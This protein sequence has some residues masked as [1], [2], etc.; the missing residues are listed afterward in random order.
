MKNQEKISDVFRSLSRENILVIIFATVL[1]FI[2]AGAIDLYLP[3]MPSMGLALHATKVDVQHTV[4]FFLIGCA[5][6][7]LIYG[8]LADRFGRKKIVIVGLLIAILGFLLAAF[9]TTI[10]SLLQARLIQGIGVGVSLMMFRTMIC[11]V[12]TG[13]HLV[14]VLSY[15]T[16]LFSMSPIISPVIGGYIEHYLSWRYC[17]L[18]LLL[19][20]VV[21]II[22]F[23]RFCPET[24]TKK[25]DIKLSSLLAHYKT[26]FTHKVFIYNTI[27]GGIGFGIIM[28]YATA[29]AFVFQTHFHLS[30]IAFGWLGIFIGLVSIISKQFNARFALRFSIPSLLVLGNS[31]ILFGGL[32]LFF[33]RNNQNFIS[34]L[35]PILIVV[36]GVAFIMGNAMSLAL[37]PFGQTRAIAA[38]IFSVLQVFVAFVA[39]AIIAY[40]AQYNVLTLSLAYIML[41]F[42]G[43]LVGLMAECPNKLSKCH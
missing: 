39:S 11:D 4:S 34:A 25:I 3:S 21:F 9:A 1:G 10:S 26:I 7:Q 6:S 31:I 5:L 32:L 24:H 41:A 2:G 15:A 22:L 23:W 28:A 40:F 43:V 29:A 33:L 17:F 35:I 42:I 18:L 12:I 13:K 37:S 38:S 14:V 19:V 27:L 20:Y 36:A 8:V 16:I 30:P